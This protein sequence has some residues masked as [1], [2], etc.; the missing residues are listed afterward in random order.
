MFAVG[1]FH[2]I[3]NKYPITARGLGIEHLLSDPKVVG[4]NPGDA[5]TVLHD[6]HDPHQ[7]A[8]I[9]SGLAKL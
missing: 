1:N 7:E 3:T 6:F 4:S 9:E 8:V 5:E 2:F